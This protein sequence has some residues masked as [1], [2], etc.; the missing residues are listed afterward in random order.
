MP[1]R[2]RGTRP[3]PQRGPARRKA[4]LA[5]ILNR[6]SIAAY[7]AP[8]PRDRATPVS[9]LPPH[10]DLSHILLAQIPQRLL[11]QG[12]DLEHEE[13]PE[14]ALP[15]P[16]QVHPHEICGYVGGAR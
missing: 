16:P 11:L 15:D 3:A 4:R 1:A 6:Y 8:T 7:R 12:V 5:R 9:E 2:A 10:V 13:V 14:T